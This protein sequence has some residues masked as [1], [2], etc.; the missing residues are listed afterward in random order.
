MRILAPLLVLFL[1]T[2]V[3]ANEAK[4]YRGLAY[5]G[6]KNERQALDVYAPTEVD[7]GIRTR[8][9]VKQEGRKPKKR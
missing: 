3:L 4:V 2:P 8:R 1:A 5:A 9:S 6:T 7:P